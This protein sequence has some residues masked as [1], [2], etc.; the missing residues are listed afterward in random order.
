VPRELPGF[1]DV[2]AAGSRFNGNAAAVP[3]R[4]DVSGVVAGQVS[5][6]AWGTETLSVRRQSP[7]LD[8]LARGWWKAFESADSALRVAGT[9]L[10]GKE[11]GERRSRLAE[12]RSK[13][14]RLLE[15]LARDLQADG[16][17][18]RWLAAPT[19]L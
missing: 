18:V 12:E 14:A 3:G 15:S 16:S 8:A 6:L 17:F 7:D 2:E 9:Y 11:L 1:D 5:A 4:Q 19:S 10:G 13:V